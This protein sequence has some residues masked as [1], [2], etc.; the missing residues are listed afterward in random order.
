MKNRTAVIGSIIASAILGLAVTTMYGGK[1]SVS[2][3]QTQGQVP[4]DLVMC[5]LDRVPASGNIYSLSHW[6]DWPP[7]PADMAKMHPDDI[8]WSS[9]AGVF[10][11]DD[12]ASEMASM[13]R[14][15]SMNES[16]PATNE[17]PPLPQPG[18][19]NYWGLIDTNYQGG[20]W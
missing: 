4:T 1:L 20:T 6:P 14:S 18:D 9:S 11:L 5:S 19:T 8:R 17:I 13:F 2:Q 3:Q 15:L 16:E 7:L 10:F 12:R